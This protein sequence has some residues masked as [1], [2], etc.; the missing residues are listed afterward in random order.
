MEWIRAIEEC[1]LCELPGGA[2]HNE[3]TPIFKFNN[4]NV[5]FRT[6]LSVNALLK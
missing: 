2:K 6:G 4:R 3:I 5:Y 1:L